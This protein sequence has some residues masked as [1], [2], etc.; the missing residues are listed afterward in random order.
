MKQKEQVWISAEDLEQEESFVKASQNEFFNLPILN[1]LADEGKAE[2]GTSGT[3]RR[4]FLK[5]VGFSL[6]A[7]TI[8]AA[9]DTP[10]RKALPYVKK[11]DTIVPGV[12]TYYASSYVRGGDY[13]PILVKTREGRPIKIE[14]NTMSPLTAGGTSARTQAS[15]L[16]LY[17][18]A[19]LRAPMKTALGSMDEL[20][21]NWDVIDEEIIEQL[22]QANNIR[23]V[24]H[25]SISPS[26]QA[27]IDMF[28][29]KYPKTEVVTYD[30]ISSSAA[31]LA[32]EKTFGIMAL[33]S[34]RFDKAN[35][36]VNFG[37]DFLGTWVSPTEF[38]HQFAQ[39]R[40]IKGADGERMSRLVQLESNMSY[41]GSNAD[42][43]VLIKPSEQ[44]LAIAKLHNAIASKTGATS[45]GI[46]G[47]LSH[48]KAEAAISVIADDLMSNR[49][50]AIVLSDSNNTAEQ[51]L[52]NAINHALGNYGNTLDFDNASYQ[53]QGVDAEMA[54]CITEM[55]AGRV[56]AIIFID[57]ANPVYDHPM[58]ADIGAALE[59]VK[60]SI[61]CTSMPS[62]TQ[63]GCS[64]LCPTPHYLES[65]G[66]VHPK[67]GHYGIVQP[68][69]SPL[70]NTRPVT[71]SILRWAEH[72]DHIGNDDPS[73]TFIKK[74]WEEH[75]FPQQEQFATFRAF[76][77]SALHDGF[78]QVTT[79]PQE[80]VYGLEV[81]TLE[82]K[83]NRLANSELEVYFYEPMGVGSGSSANNPWLQE[84]P[85]PVTRVV[86][87]NVVHIP[88]QWNGSEF[89]YFNNL[90]EDGL[91]VNLN[92]GESSIQAPVVRQFGQ[93]QGTVAIALGYGRSD[94]GK[95]GSGVGAN[96]YPMLQTDAEGN[97]QY[98]STQPTISGKV[99]VDDRFASVQHHH[100]MGVS[101]VD[102][103]EGKINVDEKTLM[104][105]GEGYQGA[106]TKRSIFRQSDVADLTHSVEE[107]Q[108]ERKHHQFL[109]DQTL[110]P[111][112]SDVY[113]AGHH[114]GMSI[115]L[116]ACIGCG[117]CQVAC[118]AENN[119]PIVGKTEVNRHHEMT[120][121][122]IDRYYYGDVESP[123]VVYQPMMCQHCDNAP[124]ENVCPV[125]ATNH[126]SEGL[127][128]MA[129]NR[130]VGT[131]YCA[132]NCPYKVRRFNWLD[133]NAA[134]LFPS[135]ENDPFDESTPYYADNLTR[136]VLNPD[137]T[138]RARGV[139]EKCSM[140][141][142]RIQEGKLTAK[143][144]RR[145]LKD[146]DIKTACQTACPTGAIVFGDMNDHDSQLHERLEDP[147]TYIA[148]EETNVRSSV[149]YMMKV[150]N[151]SEKIN[152]EEA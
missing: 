147:K 5:Y 152:S 32:N 12:A 8:A 144:E 87:D 102:D 113:E 39:R 86:W 146:G 123:N 69:I 17:D 15:V 134:D 40:K 4:D 50:N 127:N 41:T 100:T 46:N 20:S 27:A 30:P 84:M 13:C 124:C 116:S 151:Q 70:F 53:R 56:D 133:Y 118:V 75:V 47:T 43:R 106:L 122:R 66:D 91:L 81:S 22:K 97:I 83:I 103:K 104:T 129:Y 24:R 37:A 88:L 139:I 60:T 54:K 7:A 73:Y 1:D 141:V 85:D 125:A 107:L 131:R 132:N 105:L 28:L 145:Q 92:V 95:A 77:D 150:T 99:G 45:I 149:G 48:P 130:C 62:I 101:G 11:P 9:C 98:F 96:C 19:R 142:Q 89:E 16:D 18:V 136:M 10:I 34:H 74:Y 55:K 137:V 29:A 128:Q 79:T 31:L 3:Q 44:G 6:G 23:I 25:T 80:L 59:N 67:R 51:C 58:G 63:A 93:M 110:Y 112:W 61:A 42:H 114:W 38:A 26:Q 64:Y 135:N 140:C 2:T 119:V 82:G 65:W 49:G 71:E 120:W 115:D 14:G 90:A 121:M 117:A 35:L 143:S 126:S 68:T 57:D 21:G 72:T 33:P 78:A 109:N 52:I 138:V 36:I 148:L 111:D 108:E 94:T 76:W